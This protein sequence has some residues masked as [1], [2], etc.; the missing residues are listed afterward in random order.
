MSPTAHTAAKQMEAQRIPDWKLAYGI[1][2]ACASLGFGKSKLWE[3]IKDKKIEAKKDGGRT[4]ILR[5]ELQ[6]YL[7]NLPSARA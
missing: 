1:D 4:I 5:S 7:E 2:E 6:R 3:L